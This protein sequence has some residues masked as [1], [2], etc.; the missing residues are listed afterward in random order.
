MA[1]AQ[2]SDAWTQ[3]SFTVLIMVH[4]G[5][6]WACFA[7]TP[8]RNEH[9][10]KVVN[11]MK[12]RGNETILDIKCAKGFWTNG[13]AEKLKAGG[14]IYAMDMWDTEVSAQPQ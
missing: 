12:L 4:C 13:V 10:A 8:N 6:R 3:V 5:V 2:E 7:Y 14:R 9:R 1:F 11:E